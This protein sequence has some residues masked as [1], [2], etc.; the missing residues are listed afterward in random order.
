M[1]G[2][3]ELNDVSRA[4]R[5]DLLILTRCGGISAHLK[6]GRCCSCASEASSLSGHQMETRKRAMEW[7][8]SIRIADPKPWSRTLR[9]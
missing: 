3:T 4:R 5:D 9:G 2:L 8:S 6:V 1:G 7:S